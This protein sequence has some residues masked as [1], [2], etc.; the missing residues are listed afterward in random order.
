M[1]KSRGRGIS[2]LPAEID[3][4]VDLQGNLRSRRLASHIRRWH[5]ATISRPDKKYAMRTLLV[6]SAR[7]FGRAFER[8]FGRGGL[9]LM[10]QK[11][12]GKF[13]PPVPQ[14]QL[15]ALAMARALGEK[16]GTAIQ[17]KPTLKAPEPDARLDRN[18]TWLAIAPGASY[19]AKKAPAQ[20]FEQVLG[21]CVG[22]LPPEIQI[23]IVLLGDQRERTDCDELER[24]LSAQQ[25]DGPVLNLAGSTTLTETV[26]VLAGC[27]A[28]LS[29]DSSL[30]HIAESLG[31][32]AFMLFG[33]TTEAFGFAPHLP[34]SRA[35]SASLGCRPC[36]KHGKTPCR[37][38]DHAC[39]RTIDTRSA[40]DAL[41]EVFA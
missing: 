19:P 3:A 27:R 34:Q 11:T 39:F 36:S 28:I 17:I 33:P 21:R 5:G 37:Y 15:A 38:K 31:K 4:C 23:G 8:T 22:K 6:V 13:S 41:A 14:Y 12:L 24:R 9:G 25:W 7:L 16:S 26:A 2:N 35:F 32:S 29:N 10:C 20:V 18:M 30:A 40:G 1:E